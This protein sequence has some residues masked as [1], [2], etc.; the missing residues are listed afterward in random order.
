MAFWS[1]SVLFV[2]I[3]VAYSDVDKAFFPGFPGGYFSYADRNHDDTLEASE[4]D[5]IQNLAWKMIWKDFVEKHPN[6]GNEFTSIKRKTFMDL[7]LDLQGMLRIT[8]KYSIRQ[9]G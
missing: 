3:V 9:K 4:V 1:I 5:L 7:L 6:V 2:L 8:S